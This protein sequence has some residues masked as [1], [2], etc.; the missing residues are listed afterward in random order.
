MAKM[1][2]M[3]ATEK[4]YQ[5]RRCGHQRQQKTNHYGAT[6]SWGHYSTCPEC[7]PWAKYPEFGGQTFWDCLETPEGTKEEEAA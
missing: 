5:C 1:T 7:P 4:K 6:W 3:T 2:M